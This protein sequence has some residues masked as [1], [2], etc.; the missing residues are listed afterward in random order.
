LAVQ[1][2][3]KTPD[4]LKVTLLEYLATSQNASDRLRII[5]F[6]T[7]LMERESSDKARACAI[8]GLNLLYHHHHRR[9]HYNCM[10]IPRFS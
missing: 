9:Y 3:D 1:A 10:S 7:Q 8:L 4:T 2:S 6:L 5:P